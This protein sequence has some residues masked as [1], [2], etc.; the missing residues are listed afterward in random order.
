MRSAL[1]EVKGVRRAQVQL[2]GHEA[3]VT[4][5]PHETNGAA[6]IAAVNAA[7]GVFQ[8]RQYTASVKQASP[9]GRS[10]Q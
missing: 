3:T 4:Y 2:E 8:P 6:L 5:D 9:N 1:L 7:P 10:A